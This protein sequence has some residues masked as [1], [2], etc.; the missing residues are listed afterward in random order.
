MCVCVCIISGPIAEILANK[1][2]RKFTND[3][4]IAPHSVFC[5]VFLNRQ[6]EVND[7]AEKKATSIHLKQSAEFIYFVAS[8]F[9][10]S[11][12]NKVTVFNAPYKC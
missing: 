8:A 12:N 3:K 4:G 10:H 2:T 9:A 5:G 6:S 1:E 11:Q 7:A